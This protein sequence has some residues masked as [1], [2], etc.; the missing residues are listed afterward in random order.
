M[1]NIRYQ[2]RDPIYP[3]LKGSGFVERWVRQPNRL[4]KPLPFKTG[5]ITSQ[6]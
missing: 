4:A 5:Y 1:I 3:V 2:S 6:D